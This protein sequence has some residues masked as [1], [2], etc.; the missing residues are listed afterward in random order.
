MYIFL[1]VNVEKE[2]LTDDIVKIHE[3]LTRTAGRNERFL[4]IASLNIPQARL[5]AKIVVVTVNSR[6]PAKRPGVWLTKF[7]CNGGSGGT[8]AQWVDKP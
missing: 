3:F 4:G 5:E 6:L 8:V 2:K 1:D 7:Y